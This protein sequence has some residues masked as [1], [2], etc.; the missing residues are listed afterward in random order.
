VKIGAVHIEN[1]S[2]VSNKTIE[3]R[4][5]LK[6]PEEVKVEQLRASLDR[7]Y[8]IGAFDL[9]DFKLEDRNGSSDLIVEPHERATGR[10][11][12]RAGLRLFTDLDADSDFNF[13][14]TITATELN[15]LGAEWKNQVQFGRTTRVF[16][17]WYQPLNYNR[18]LFVAPYGEFLQDRKEGILADGNLFR[19]KYRTFR[20]G[21][22][23]GAQLGNFGELR[24]G[25][26]WGSTRVY[27]L[28]GLSLPGGES[29]I[30]Q[31]GG[32]VRLT[33]D[34]FD[35]VDFPRAGYLGGAEFYSAREELGS[36]L[37]YN[38]VAAAWNH[39]FSFGE[40]TLLPGFQVGAKI[41]P[42]LPFYEAFSLGGFLN[43]SGYPFEGLSDQYTAFAR[44]IFYRRVMHFNKRAVEAIYLG[45]S[46]ETGG[47]WHRF[48]DI[49]AQDLIFAGSVFVGADTLFG[50]LYFAYG[51]AEGG[52]HAFY[53]YLGRGF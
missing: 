5:E 45:G 44:L 12:L 27:E 36:R 53:F 37:N 48:D 22:D 2:R 6:P 15:Q 21:M 41:G 40:N 47:V 1:Q 25:P 30:T 18:S 52:N 10:I 9:V 32:H 31:A 7:V 14:T 34:Q 8:D 35:N 13:L 49:T 4:L 46:A 26:V 20:G 3:K 17:E 19:A 29:R 23:G 24:V 42:D 50:P 11:H 33:I 16:S 51:Q 38:K 39:A 43:L 28:R